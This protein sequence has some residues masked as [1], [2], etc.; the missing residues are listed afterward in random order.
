LPR[1]P[2]PRPSAY[3]STLKIGDHRY[4]VTVQR[5]VAG[6]SIMGSIDYGP[7]LIEV[8]T[9]SGRTGL[10]YSPH[11][12]HDTFWHE[13]THGI[14]KEMGHH[15]WSSERFVTRFANLLTRAIESARFKGD[16]R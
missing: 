2:K 6:R 5:R 7:K 10:A 14:L 13:V 9:H 8:A 1:S 15:L 4:Q 3:P 16:A 11:E 12:V